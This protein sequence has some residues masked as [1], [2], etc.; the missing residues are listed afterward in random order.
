MLN[1][2]LIVNDTKA[3]VKSEIV[4]QIRHLGSTT[5]DGLERAVFESL[6]GHTREEVDWDVE[7]NQAGYYTWLKTF[8]GLVSELIEDGYILA[9]EAGCLVATEEE[10]V[11]EYSHVVYPPAPSS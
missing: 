4:K 5:P 3:L 8:D 7:D 1:E 10:P 6:V 2:G 9:E 11:S